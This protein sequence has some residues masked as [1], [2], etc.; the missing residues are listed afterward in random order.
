M[1]AMTDPDATQPSPS[2]AEP[3]QVS[4]AQMRTLSLVWNFTRDDG[5]TLVLETGRNTNHTVFW[6]VSDRPD[7]HDVETFRSQEAFQ[8]RLDALQQEVRV[9]GWRLA[10]VSWAPEPNDSLDQR[11]LP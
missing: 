11:A 3:E 2:T 5:S 8:G 7:E 6:I 9:A 10:S 1:H 4:L